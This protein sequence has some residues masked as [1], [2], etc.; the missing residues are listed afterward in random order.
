[1]WDLRHDKRNVR[2]IA[3]RNDGTIADIGMERREQ[4]HSGPS[5]RSQN[6]SFENIMVKMGEMITES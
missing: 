1:M 6:E 5:L 4:H 3:H 2:R